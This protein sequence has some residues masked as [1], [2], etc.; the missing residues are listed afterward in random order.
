MQTTSDGKGPASAT[1]VLPPL[2]LDTVHV[3]NDSMRPASDLSSFFATEDAMTC[4][5][6]Q[7]ARCSR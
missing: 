1:F 2:Y 3:C 6:Q 4:F 7:N 5:G